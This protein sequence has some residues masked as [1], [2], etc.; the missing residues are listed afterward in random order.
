VED[1]TTAVVVVLLTV[2]VR[3]SPTCGSITLA[4]DGAGGEGANEAAASCGYSSARTSMS[5]TATHRHGERI[6]FCDH[7]VR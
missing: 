4:E 3:V 1:S 7:C 5:A 6:L 2:T